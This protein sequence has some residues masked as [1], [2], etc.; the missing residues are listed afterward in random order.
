MAK[1]VMR[2]A[3]AFASLA[4]N[5][6][7]NVANVVE[8]IRQPIYDTVTYAAAGQTN[9]TFF[10]L[11]I[12]QGGKTKV[13]TNMTTAGSLPAPQNFLCTAIH[14]T[15]K[16]NASLTPASQAA[17]LEGASI[18]EDTY[19]FGTNGLLEVQVGSKVQLQDGPLGLFPP[20]TLMEV[21]L[22]TTVAANAQGYGQWKGMVYDLTPI[23]IPWGQ[24]FSVTLNWNAAVAL[25]S[26]LAGTVQCRMDGYLYRLAQ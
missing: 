1:E 17:S 3:P 18:V 12:G 25:P 14:L 23:L 9:L 10:A 4:Q 6:G 21:N 19:V 13:D 2:K 7:V 15:F 8:A 26:T 22:S 24:N 20:A 5:Y 16:P 11:P